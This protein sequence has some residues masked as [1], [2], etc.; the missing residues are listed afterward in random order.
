MTTKE[1][2]TWNGARVNVDEILVRI[3]PC[4]AGRPE[5]V[6]AYVFGSTARA[7]ARL[8]S[9][10]DIAVFLTPEMAQTDLGPFRS[11]LLTELLACLSRNDV[12]LVILNQAPAVLRHRV[13]RD[14]VLIFSR[15]ETARVGFTVDTLR[16][17]VDTAPLRRLAME[18]TRRSVENG[19]YGRAVPFRTVLDSRQ[20]PG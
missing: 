11:M 12:D 4:I 16:R 6:F 15:D 7:E 1:D 2:L 13:L 14:G 18:Y 10:V 8:D 17:Y 9:D 20:A 19:T 5:V 3:L